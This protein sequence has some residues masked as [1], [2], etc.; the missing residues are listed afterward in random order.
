MAEKDGIE[1]VF[2][3]SEALRQRP[4]RFLLTLSD[5]GS[6]R[7]FIKEFDSD[8]LMFVEDGF[9]VPVSKSDLTWLTP[10]KTLLC[11]GLDED[12][13]TD[14]G[15]P[16]T[17]KV[18]SRGKSLSETTTIYNGRKSDVG[19]GVT[20]FE[21]GEK[22]HFIISRAV[23]FYNSEYSIYSE[24]QG[25]RPLNI[26][27]EC[28]ILL[29]FK[30]NLIFRDR[31]GASG[32]PSG[33][34][35]SQALSDSTSYKKPDQK[36]LYYFNS[37][38]SFTGIAR[39]KDSLIV[40]F[41]HLVSGRLA[42][43]KFVDGKLSTDQ[44]AWADKSSLEI[45]SSDE[46]SNEVLYTLS[47]YLTPTSVYYM[48][49][50]EEP[51]LLYQAKERFNAE[52]LVTSQFS[53]ESKDGTHIPYFIVSKEKHALDPKAPLLLYGYGGFEESLLPSYHG[54]TGKLWLER[55]GSY[56]IANIRGG[57]EFGPAWHEAA[58]TYRRQNAFDDFIAVAEDLIAKGYC[59]PE[60]L[61]IQGGSNGGLLVGAVAMQRPEL[62]GAVLCEVP[63]LDML[64]Y[65][66]L[67][68]GASWTAEYGDPDDVGARRYLYAYSPFHNVKAERTYP[69]IMLSTATGDDR[70]HPGHARRMAK[71]LQDLSK[72]YLYYEN[73]KG[74]H[75]DSSDLSEEAKA[76]ALSFTY[77]WTELKK[78]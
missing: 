70:V 75:S 2:S 46:H 38:Q 11:D 4:G 50:G 25:L 52:G 28:D 6:D 54:I 55:G 21:D 58:R 40:S 66:E 7:S 56:V 35:V 42:E 30:G 41:T 26:H 73:T 14:S 3:S 77:L 45:L 62:F 74:G 51:R 10:D 33:S 71:R 13:L 61:G 32:F 72:P 20:R 44:I 57:G 49:V 18:W 37:H 53:A 64:I 68:A 69:R 31:L 8:R 60:T 78:G 59:T 1:Y 15:Y 9:N 22:E 19:V 43:I 23:D 17:I 76:Y 63:L 27:S 34:I 24:S 67:L 29:I 12:D 48:K 5:G 16:M 47:S 39:T 36:L 65:H